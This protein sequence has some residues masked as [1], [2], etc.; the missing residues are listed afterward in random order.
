MESLASGSGREG[1]EVKIGDMTQAEF[2][3]RPLAR[4]RWSFRSDKEYKAWIT[5]H[6]SK[7]KP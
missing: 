4:P 7:L 6:L 3:A 1:G 5:K 2:N